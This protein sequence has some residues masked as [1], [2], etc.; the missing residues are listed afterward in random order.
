MKKILPYMVIEANVDRELVTLGNWYA[1]ERKHACAAICQSILQVAGEEISDGRAAKRV[2]KIMKIIL[3]YDFHVVI[4][5]F[6]NFVSEEKLK[7]AVER[8][9]FDQEVA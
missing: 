7:K 4:S 6:S 3:R 9:I 5:D 1:K 2:R 8:L